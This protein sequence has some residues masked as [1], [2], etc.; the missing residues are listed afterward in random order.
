VTQL[1]DER[2]QFP[3][4]FIWGTAAAAHQAEG[5]NWNNDWWAWEH[6]PR[7][8]CVE[9]SGDAI[10]HYNRFDAD[11]ALLASYGH[12]AHRFSIEWSRIEPEEG[13][14]STVALDHY[15]HVLDSLHAH[16]LQPFM[17]LHH[18]SS[19]R[20]VAADGGWA[21]PA[22]VDRFRR[23]TDVVARRLGDRVPYVCTINEPQI[24]ALMG[25]Q[26]NVFPPGAGDKSLFWPVTRNFVAAHQTALETFKARV[27]DAKVG[28]TLAVTDFQ[29]AD[30]DAVTLRDRIHHRM[31]QTYYDAIRDG[32]V[33]GPGVEEEIP[34]LSPKTNDFVGV[35][36]YSR[37]VISKDG[38]V[39]PDEGA[40]TTQMGYE[41]VPDSFVT[42]L[43][44]A[45]DA[46]VPVFVTE[47]GIGTSDDKQRVRYIAT[48]L[49]SVKRAIDASVDLR[50][51]IYWCA[52]DNFERALGYRP[53]FGLIACD[54]TTFERIPKPSADY[55][56]EICRSNAVDPK[57]TAQYLGT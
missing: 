17:T 13:E 6:D 29:A 22:I 41:V 3:D 48:H 35:Q 42:V 1:P 9:P 44:N 16:G 20:W 2:L 23:Y 46:G 34:G 19:P 12:A 54:R 37:S 30:D 39:A 43:E 49:A 8:P 33:R 50:G 51:Y 45:A 25:Y 27:P 47:N 15:A 53:T 52:I 18:F 14:F 55:F 24:V 7:S 28:I 5:G 31:V 11:F 38:A 40:E 57:V 32:W 4:G 21:N 10:D 26:L 56:G 36:F